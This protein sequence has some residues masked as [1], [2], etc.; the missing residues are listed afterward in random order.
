[1]S[2]LARTVEDMHKYA[3]GVP[4][5]KAPPFYQCGTCLACKTRK[6]SHGPRKTT[7]RKP[8]DPE[9]LIRPGQHL[10]MDFGSVRGSSW[11]AKNEDGKL[12]TSIDGHRSYLIVV[13]RFT[14]YKWVFNTATK[15]PSLDEVESI[16]R[17]F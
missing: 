17:K 9:E 8:P 5:L 2:A 14:R 12:V 6:S 11:H 10:H 7:E 16:L 1:M 13:D 4:K 3:L 15:K